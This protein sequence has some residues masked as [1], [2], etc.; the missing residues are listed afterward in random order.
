[1]TRDH[2]PNDPH[3][4]RRGPFRALAALAVLAVP[5]CGDESAGPGDRYLHLAPDVA[6]SGVS[7]FQSVEVPLWAGGVERTELNAVLVDGKAAAVVVSL[8]PAAGFDGREITV[9]LAIE[10]DGVVRWKETTLTPTGPSSLDRP[11]SL[12]VFELTAEEFSGTPAV[13]VAVVDP[14]APIAAVGTPHVARYPA[15]GTPRP[16][17]LGYA[18]NPVRLVLIPIRYATGGNEYVPDTSAEQLAL[19]RETLTAVYPAV[20]WDI[21][22]HDEVYWDRPSGW[23][24]FN[25][26]A[27]N[28]YLSDLKASEGDVPESHYYALVSPAAS[29]AAY[30]TPACV[31]G[32]SYL[33]TDA[34]MSNLRVGA[35][36]GFIGPDSAWTMVHELGHMFGRG[37]SGCS[38]AR[39]DREY[40]YAGGLI[41]VWGRDPRNDRFLR[42]DT[43]DFMGYCTP[44]W[45]SDF[46]WN[47]LFQ[48]LL[49]LGR[50]YAKRFRGTYRI[51]HVD[52]D[53][54]TARWGAAMPG[55]DFENADSIAARFVAGDIGFTQAIPIV[56]QSDSHAAA[57]LVPADRAADLRG[58]PGLESVP[59]P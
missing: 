16:L 8:E 29:F 26:T 1:M 44:V 38:V 3:R 49:D 19:Y 52:F 42:P 48:R 5:A 13:A 25:F 36:V 30:C 21:V 20:A 31:A 35:G 34:S 9:A 14:V 10:R 45:T 41:G 28:T 22:L 51:L 59:P 7:I 18:P 6:V 37:H 23:T 54:E 53:D 57:V 39:D 46:T 11:A 17:T 47:R 24:G 33:V 32:Q 56:W 43:A 27:L 4:C 55:D 50:L 40:P 12:A 2:R 15:D 58:L